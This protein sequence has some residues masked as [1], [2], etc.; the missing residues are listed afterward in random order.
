[1]KRFMMLG[2]LTVLFSL[3]LHAAQNASNVTFHSPMQVGSTTLPAG[4]YKA[5][6]TGNGPDVQV[7]LDAHGQKPVTV[8]ARLVA[9][10]SSNRSLEINT[11]NGVDILQK[12][13]LEKLT[14]VLSTGTTSGM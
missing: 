12:I 1:M 6:W 10:K 9:V 7:T 11:V 14:L 5:T 2:F 13:V 8:P 4:D 3:S